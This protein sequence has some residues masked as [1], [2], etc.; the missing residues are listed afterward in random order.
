MLNETLLQLQSRQLQQLDRL[1]QLW[2]HDELLAEL[3]VEA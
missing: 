2:R 3:Q 1:L